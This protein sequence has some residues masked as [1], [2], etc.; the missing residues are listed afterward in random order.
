ME[1]SKEAGTAMAFVWWTRR[2]M[3]GLTHDDTCRTRLAV[4]RPVGG[5]WN[6]RG[7]P[8]VGDRHF[9]VVKGVRAMVLGPVGQLKDALA[10]V[11]DHPRHPEPD[12][13]LDG[14]VTQPVHDLY[15]GFKR[16]AG[17]RVMIVSN[18]RQNGSDAYIP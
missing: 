18:W 8:D 6:E 4:V 5:T 13:V 3:N 15:R 16:K 11:L 2:S 14:K 9:R 7:R 17:L 12:E 1:S 10:E